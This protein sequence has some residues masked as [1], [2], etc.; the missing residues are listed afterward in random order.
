MER[1]SREKEERKRAEE[2]RID[3]EKQKRLQEAKEIALKQ[4]EEETLRIKE[5]NRRMKEW[6]E[7][8][9]REQKIKEEKLIQKF[10]TDHS[11][12]KNN[13]EVDKNSIKSDSPEDEKIN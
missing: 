6:E 8:F 5:E 4:Q 7:K 10:Y 12:E 3:E 1:L 13:I 11:V 2:L 9:D